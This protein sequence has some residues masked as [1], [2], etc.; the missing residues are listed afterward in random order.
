LKDAVAKALE[1]SEGIASCIQG[2]RDFWT[3]DLGTK[4]LVGEG[5]LMIAEAWIPVLGEAEV[6]QSVLVVGGG[7]MV[8]CGYDLAG[9]SSP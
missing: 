1:A 6:L 8:G 3:T 5:T 9:I 4:I 7:S 2:I